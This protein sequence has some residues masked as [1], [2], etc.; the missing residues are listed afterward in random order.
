MAATSPTMSDPSCIA[1]DLDQFRAFLR[2]IVMHAAVGTALGGVTTIVG[3]PQNVL[4]AERMGWVFIEFFLRMAPVTLPVLVVGLVTCV[5]LEKFKGVRL[6][7]RNT[8]PRCSS[9]PATS[10]TT[11]E[12]GPAHAP[13]RTPGW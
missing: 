7:H 12:I 13:G 11:D 3:E 6:R 2:G 10:T 8:G 5:L 1:A 9:H 4:I